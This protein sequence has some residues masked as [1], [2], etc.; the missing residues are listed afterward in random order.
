MLTISAHKGNANQNH[1]KIPPYINSCHQ[2]Y[3]QQ[4]V[5]VRMWGKR[6]PNATAGGNKS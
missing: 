6:N 4:K 3:H 5:L 2:K 1:M